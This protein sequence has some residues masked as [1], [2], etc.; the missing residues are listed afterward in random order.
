MVDR[1]QSPLIDTSLAPVRGAISNSD[2]VFVRGADESIEKVL[3]SDLLAGTAGAIRIRGEAD[4]D[5]ASTTPTS[6]VIIGDPNNATMEQGVAPVDTSPNGVAYVVKTAQ[7][8]VQ[9]QISGTTQTVFDGDQIIWSG[10]KWSILALGNAVTSVD[11]QTGAVN[12]ED[13]YYWTGNKPNIGDIPNLQGTLDS[14]YSP[15]NKPTP[16]E[17]GAKANSYVPDWEE[18]TNKP[19]TS[20]RWPSF[21]EVT[22]K[23]TAATRW[24][25]FSEVTSKPDTATRWPAF[26]EVT[27]K[28]TYYPTTWESVAA[29][30]EQATRWPTWSEVTGKPTT[31]TPS[32]HTHPISQI[33]GLG[34]AATTKS[35]D[36]AKSRGRVVN[37]GNLFL[38]SGMYGINGSPDNTV[39]HFGAM[40][41]ANNIDTGLQIS[42]GHSSDQLH[43]RGWSGSGSAFTPWRRVYHTGNMPATA[44]RWPTFAEVTGKP[45][46][47]PTTWD[48]VTGKPSI[49]TTASDI[50]AVSKTGDTMSGDLTIVKGD[51]ISS[52]M[53]FLE[54]NG[55]HGALVK[56]EADEANELQLITRNN[57]ANHIKMKTSR[58]PDTPIVFN[59]PIYAYGD[60][61]YTE[62]YKPTKADVGLSNV[63]NYTISNATNDPSTNKFASTAAVYSVSQ[64]VTALEGAGGSGGTA[65][66]IGSMMDF[67]PLPVGK[68]PHAGYIPMDGSLISRT[69]YQDLWL[70]ANDMGIVV[71]EAD[72]QSIKASSHGGAVSVYSVGTGGDTFRVP[73]VGTFGMVQ[74]PMGSTRP[75]E[76]DRVKGFADQLKSHSHTV[77]VDAGGSHRHSLYLIYRNSGVNSQTQEFFDTAKISSSSNT[78]CP[79]GTG[80]VFHAKQAVDAVGNHTHT[81]S[82]NPT[83]GSETTMKYMW[84]TKWIYSGKK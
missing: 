41:V 10:S 34:T 65:L 1:I 77:T 80:T 12:L 32:A 53:G 84:C 15:I 79:Q 40:I 30:P 19:D 21:A 81:A 42:G 31:Y 7:S 14:K 69:D 24:P 28:P 2:Y 83:G 58:F 44:T 50:G 70:W 72:W 11:N 55:I 75:S 51:N 74:R 57:N 25:T 60:K 13:K 45:T 22:D 68:V 35:T 82:A 23:P 37:D 33:T 47:F 54:A 49:P 39:S 27:G 64:R 73:D 71:S 20:T 66:M 43:F 61:V 46:T 17:I 76:I 4:M 6:V 38:A 48:L 62:G 36:Y 56:Y 8:G 26:S 3:V 63:P 5:N 52:A 18:I 9:T 59:G 29:K 16:L 78:F 67:P